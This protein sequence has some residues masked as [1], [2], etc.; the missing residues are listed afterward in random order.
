[1]KFIRCQCKRERYGVL[2]YMLGRAGFGNCN[3]LTIADGPGQRDSGCRATMG[4]ADTCKRG[5]AQQASAGAAERRVGHHRHAV[6]L[7]PWQQ[8]TLDAAIVEV[9]KDL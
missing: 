3:D 7:A 9:I 8:I 1:M 6:L 4:G 2:P 5:V